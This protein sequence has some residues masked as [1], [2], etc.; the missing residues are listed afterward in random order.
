MVPINDLDT[1]LF[2]TRHHEMK[3]EYGKINNSYLFNPKLTSMV[4]TRGCPYRCRF[5]ARNDYYCNYR[6]RSAE[7][8]V[9]EIE[10][11]NDNYKTVIITDENF[12]TDTKIAHKIM[13]SLIEI[14]TSIDKMIEGIRVDTANKRSL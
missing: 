5:C 13:N 4:T 3:Y 14:G 6:K 9:K 2:P 7:N 10:E 8:V 11:L 1:I 12:L